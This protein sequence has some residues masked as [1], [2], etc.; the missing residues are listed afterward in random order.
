[1]NEVFSHQSNFLTVFSPCRELVPRQ[2]GILLL[3]IKHTLLMRSFFTQTSIVILFS[4]LSASLSVSFAQVEVR[5]TI[6]SGNAST[7]CTDILTAPDPLWRVNVENEGWVT[8]PREGNCFTALPNVQYTATYDCPAGVPSTLQLC[9]RAFENDGLPFTCQIVEDCAETIC[10]T[11]SIP[12][13]GTANYTLAL[14][15]G[16]SSGGSVS[17]SITTTP[18]PTVAYDNICNSINLG[19]ISFGQQLGDA[20]L[21]LYHNRCATGMNE[22]NPLA[23]VPGWN[24]E[25]GVWFT[26]TTSADPGSLIILEARDDP[27]NSGDNMDTQIAV[28]T[29]SNNTCTGAMQFVRA[30]ADWSSTDSRLDL[31]CP[32]PNTTYFVLVDG[33]FIEA[34]GFQGT[35]GFQARSVAVPEAADAPCDAENLGAV[36]EGGMVSTNGQRSNFCATSVND[37]FVPAFSVQTSVWFQ[38]TAPPSGHVIIEGISDTQIAPWAVQLAL[39]ASS[40]NTCSGT[41]LHVASRFDG[42]T[43]DETLQVSC[44]YPGQPYWV[45]FDGFGAGGRGIFSLRIRDAGDITPV[46]NQNVTICAGASLTVGSSVY[47]VSGT[48]TNRIQVFAGCDS[49]VNTTLTVLPPISLS[50][51]QNLP[52]FGAGASNGVATAS[53]IGGV[54]NFS[55]QWCNGET[56][57]QATALP[58]GQS[59]SVTV[60]DGFGCT[61]VETIFIDQALPLQPLFAGST[62]RCAG[63]SDG[64]VSFSISEGWPP[65]NYSWQEVGGSANGSGAINAEG[66]QVILSGLRAGRYQVT[67]SDTFA[68]NVFSVDVLAP[69]ALLITANQ[70]DSASCFSFCDGLVSITASGGT[71]AYQYAWS[72]AQA[73]GPQI[74]NLCAGNYQL[75]VTDANGCLAVLPVSIGEPEEFIA[76]ATVLR[77]VSCFGGADGQ[78]VVVTNG[79]PAAYAWSSGANTPTAGQLATGFYDVTVTNADGCQDIASIFIPQPVAPVSA[80]ITEDKAVTCYGFSDA[81]LSAQPGGPGQSFTFSWSN[82]FGE[83]LNAGL[84]AGPYSVTVTNELGCK[85]EAA[86]TL[87]QPDSITASLEIEHINCRNIAQG[88]AIFIENVRGGNGMYSFSLDGAGFGSAPIFT[89]LQPGS[90]VL[91]IRDVRG[92]TYRFPATVDAPPVLTVSLGED[93][94]IPLGDSITLTAETN[95]PAPLF[96]WKSSEGDDPLADQSVT[97]RPVFNTAYTVTVFDTISFCSVSDVILVMVDKTRRVFIPNAFSPNGDGHNDTF[98]PFGGTD[99]RLVRQFHVF[100]RSGAMLFSASDTQAN[101][102]ANGWDGMLKGRQL[103]PGVYVWMAELEFADGLREVFK[104]DVMLMR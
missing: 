68:Q 35:F 98:F 40:N 7:T 50:L 89:G 59:C 99:V 55:Y 36:P 45:M 52:A 66:E 41:M 11:F 9:F 4:L 62:L 91:N 49:I 72:G 42:N 38:F 82:G 33:D 1:M 37:P 18:S 81:I 104:G 65:Y 88:G 48:Y 19:N 63:D 20:S 86:Y 84:A 97:V 74:S 31:W 85:G 5:V 67:V 13:S 102:P 25:Y 70:V 21:G 58:G 46:T 8:Y 83:R 32:R 22:P 76:T 53:A 15:A 94:I 93:L 23:F 75:S 16:L 87:S 77:P 69:P 57:P 79:S 30:I 90:Y 2:T 100:S 10:E 64:S 29:S 71:G 61:Q 101:D 78:A 103:P 54:G 92:C 34:G 60:T 14:P 17:F 44:L 73:P 27:Q 24:N 12:A 39:F 26:F 56:G 28:Y 95:S 80:V 43:L 51:T 47:T 6:Q 96:T 3:L